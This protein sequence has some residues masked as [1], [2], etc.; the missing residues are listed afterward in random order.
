M[1]IEDILEKRISY[2]QYAWGELSGEIS[3]KEVLESIQTEKY[4]R[5]VNYLRNLLSEGRQDEYDRDKKKLPGVTFS[6][7]FQ[8]KRKKQSLTEYHQ[9]IVLDI[10]KLDNNELSR[11]SKILENDKYVFTSWDSPSKKGKK[12]LVFLS[13]EELFEDIDL[14]TFHKLAFKKV[15]DYFEVTY[16]VFLDESG[17]DTT[18]LCFYSSDC[19]LH[20]KED[21]TPFNVPF[22]EVELKTEINNNKAEAILK[23]VSRKDALFNSTNKN[24]NFHRKSIQSIIRFL[25]KNKLSITDSYNDWYRVAISLTNTFTYDLAE[26]YFLELSRMDISK[27]NNIE[28]QNLLLYFFENK[29]IY[30][31]ESDQIT[32][33]TIEYFAR[34]KGYEKNKRGSTEDAKI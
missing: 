25:N 24:K 19:H 14:N 13:F 2:Q 22:T 1:K 30:L 9:I 6:A 21:L 4:F 5:Q 18:R 33:S 20:M 17:S 11:V 15:K 26:K 3:I 16:D 29:K 28:C 34:E 10:D 31:D 23:S 8:E 7:A 27:F 12:G 32:Y